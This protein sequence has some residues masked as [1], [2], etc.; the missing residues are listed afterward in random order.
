MTHKPPIVVEK[1][2]EQTFGTA[3][4]T[5]LC[6]SSFSFVEENERC[7]LHARNSVG[8]VLHSS[9]S[10]SSILF[11]KKTRYAGRVPELSHLTQRIFPLF[12]I[13]NQAV[14]IFC[15]QKA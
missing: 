14:E 1:L 2:R 5:H 6:L 11:G 9:M 4:D 15:T 13:S 8:T 10:S 7:S 12:C 3:F